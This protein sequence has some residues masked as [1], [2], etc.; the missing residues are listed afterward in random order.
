MGNGVGL[1]PSSTLGEF[2]LCNQH[3]KVSYNVEDVI[4]HTLGYI[5]IAKRDISKSFPDH[6]LD[7]YDTLLENL[8]AYQKQFLEQKENF[9]RQGKGSYYDFDKTFVIALVDSLAKKYPVGAQI[10]TAPEA[11]TVLQDSTTLSKPTI[12]DIVFESF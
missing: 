6:N 7:Y 9:I 4:K 12:K 8:L 11:P 2:L 5:E 10:P 1:Q 3:S